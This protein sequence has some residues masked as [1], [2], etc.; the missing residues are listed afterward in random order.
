MV[1]MA[2]VEFR[3]LGL[4]VVGQLHRKQ[5]ERRHGRPCPA[6]TIGRNAAV[7]MFLR[8]AVSH[9]E[10]WAWQPLPVRWA[11]GF[12]MKVADLPYWAATLCTT[13]LYSCRRSA[14]FVSVE[15]FRPSSC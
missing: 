4:P 1:S 11:K 10:T 15:N 5:K 13:Y 3:A 9:N 12:G 7:H 6:V 2:A 14:I 8:P